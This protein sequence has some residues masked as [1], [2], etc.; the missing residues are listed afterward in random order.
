M[1]PL[2]KQIAL[3]LFLVFLFSSLSYTLI[4]FRQDISIGNGQV[5]RF[6]MWCPAF[7]AFATSALCRI[8]LS[9][10]GWSWR[11]TKYE[12]LGYLIPLLYATP[13]YLVCWITIRGSIRLA[14]AEEQ[15]AKL[16]ALPHSPHLAFFGIQLPLLATVGIILSL[17]SATG[18][19]IGWRGFLLP[20]LVTRFGFTGGCLLSGCIWAFWHYPLLL[21]ANYNAGTNPKYALTCF[22]LMVVADA[23]ILGWLRLKSGSLWPCAML[24]ASHNLFIQATLDRLTAPVGQ[25]RYLTTEFGAGMVF[26]IGT[27]ALFFWLGRK[28]LNLTA[29]VAPVGTTSAQTIAPQTITAQTVY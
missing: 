14:P 20:R 23:Y 29:P 27:M 25:A 18:E 4:I 1:R 12:L 11:P 26:T 3:F 22:T 17:A 2:S 8:D 6:L 19:E 10:L 7:A 24:H 9:S 16:F 21:G 5:V 28:Q 15:T 13:V